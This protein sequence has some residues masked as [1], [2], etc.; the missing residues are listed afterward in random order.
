MKIRKWFVVMWMVLALIASHITVG[1][2]LYDDS[3]KSSGLGGLGFAV[4]RVYGQQFRDA[5]ANP[6]VVQTTSVLSQTTDNWVIAG[7]AGQLIDVCGMQLTLDGV[8]PTVRFQSGTGN[9][10]ATGTTQLTGVMQG[11]TSGPLQLSIPPFR[12]VMQTATT[13]DHFCVDVSATGGPSLT[14]WLSFVFVRP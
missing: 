14:G 2:I 5:C 3:L 12:T 9:A 4:D 7:T 10:C 6:A 1:T 13:G 8:R 11:P